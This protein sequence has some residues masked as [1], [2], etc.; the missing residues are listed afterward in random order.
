MACPQFTHPMYFADSDNLRKYSFMI[1]KNFNSNPTIFLVLISQFLLSACGGTIQTESSSA[2]FIGDKDIKSLA[3]ISI[4]S[5][6]LLIKNHTSEYVLA[7]K[8]A[9]LEETLVK[10][11]HNAEL[12]KPDSEPYYANFAETIKISN[13]NSANYS[14]ISFTKKTHQKNDE[15]ENTE[16]QFASATTVKFL[17]LVRNEI[18]KK[19]ISHYMIILIPRALTTKGM[20]THFWLHAGLYSSKTN[21]LVWKYESEVDYYA[22]M[23]HKKVIDALI[24]RMKFDNIKANYIELS[25]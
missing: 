23:T 21:Q 16:K 10:E 8:T 15:I 7:R 1:N 9:S 5:V 11:F 3:I 22:P 24:N 25:P 17:S 4:S 18:R 13:E 6:P 14:G 19:G 20:I 12:F 2:P